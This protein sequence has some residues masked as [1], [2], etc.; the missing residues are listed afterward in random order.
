MLK[1]HLIR[2]YKG[3]EH[4][5]EL[6]EYLDANPELVDNLFDEGLPSR[7]S[8][9]KAWNEHLPTDNARIT[10]RI[11]AN[12]F[13][14]IAQEQGVPAPSPAFQPKF[15]TEDLSDPDPEEPSVKE[16]AKK[17]TGEI[18]K[19]SKP[20]ID[21]NYS[22]DR[23]DNK[24]IHQNTW[25]RAEAYLAG[26]EEVFA[27]SGLDYYDAVS[28][29][30]NVHCG[31]YHRDKLREMDIDEIRHYH[32]QATRRI[33]KDARREGELD[34]PTIASLDI[35][36]SEQLSELSNVEGW[37]PDPNKCNVTAEWILG[38][39]DSDKG[40]DP[41][42]NYYFQWAGIRT[43]GFSHPVILDGVPVHRGMPRY[44][45]VD[46][47]LEHSTDMV[48]IDILLMDREFDDDQVKAVC[49]KHDVQFLN[50]E[51]MRLNERAT[52]TRLRQQRQMVHVEKKTLDVSDEF[53][54]DI[55][56]DDQEEM[57]D[58][59]IEEMLTYYRTYVP[60]KSPDMWAS[61]IAEIE[62]D[63]SDNQSDQD[64]TNE[65]TD[66]N[67]PP[68]TQ[69]QLRA[70]FATDVLDLEPEFVG[71]PSDN[72]PDEQHGFE[73][74][75]ADYREDEEQTPTRGSREDKQLYAVFATDHPDLPTDFE[76]VTDQAEK[77]DQVE[78]FLEK[79]GH[80]WD[81]EENWKYQNVFRVNTISRDHVYRFF[82]FMFSATLYNVWKI[83]DLL[84]KLSYHEEPPRGSFVQ[85]QMFLQF[86]KQ[87][88]GGGPP[89]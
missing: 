43:V 62:S 11:I 74:L 21:Q 45:I 86:A 76:D 85:R 9:W 53:I 18:W 52:C 66:D 30:D 82:N 14:Q 1:A 60:A 31:R 27:E 37:D 38:Y 69:D 17:K 16:F 47:L 32:R 75:V 55:L 73:D 57:S 24:H 20:Y 12:A 77:L 13:V 10:L 80:R 40:E 78:T 71:E 42:I 34:R 58:E 63:N 8:L 5:D 22:L 3:I 44:K 54:N 72:F 50:P 35:T 39:D 25:W 67:E 79:Y 87:F 56:R 28:D 49:M 6:H 41:D 61:Q 46:E 7:S 81:I 59:E 36:K 48:N 64:S 33:I 83:V 29:R 4:E 19:K 89:T 26:H 65:E 23:A 84:V 15:N 68:V 2:L 51:Q 88:F 70:E